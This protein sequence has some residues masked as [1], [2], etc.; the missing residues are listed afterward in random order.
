MPRTLLILL[1]LFIL[2]SEIISQDNS[3]NDKLRE[4]V[5]ESGQAEVTVPYTGRNEV[6]YLSRKLSVYS[7]RDRLV[8]I[9]ISPLTL[10]W[11]ISQDL[12][13][14][15]IE[16][17]GAKGL[18]T[19]SGLAQAM[20][21]NT[22][23]TYT[24]Y[25]SIMKYFSIRYPSLC[26]LDTIGY[27]INNRL[28]LALKISD[29]AAT[30]ENEPEVFYS[31]TMHGDET[32]GFVLM[33]RFIDYLLKNYNTVD[34]VRNLVDNLEIWINPLA[35]PD[36][37][38]RSGNTITS[39]VRVNAEGADLNRRFPD[40]LDPTIVVAK[41]N[42]DM[43]KFMRKR[44][45]VISANF[46]GGA[47][48]VNYPWDRWFSKY[49]AD[50]SWFLDISRA[51]ADTV[52]V[53]SATGYMTDESDGVT[54]GADW[55]TI[56]G[57]RQDFVTWEL[58]GREV[59]IELDR[60]K[61][62]PAA[63]LELLWLYN[64][65]SLLGYLENALS[66]IHGTVR[67]SATYAPVGAKVFISGHDK[68]SSHVYSDTLNGAFVRMLAP[69]SYSVTFSAPGYKTKTLNN[70][71][72]FAGQR[73]DIAVDM[74][75]GF[76]NIGIPAG[77]KPTLYPNPATTRLFAIL[78]EGFNGNINV[79][80][81]SISGQVVSRYNTESGPGL[82]VTT[83]ISRLSGGTYVIKFTSADTGNSSCGRF[84]V[85]K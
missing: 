43:I 67:D 41:E 33:L 85:V 71:D 19:A 10:E 23:P 61:L 53:Y 50:D 47:E 5:R 39:P 72:V 76:A 8:Y 22:Y 9:S 60:I 28:V 27:S 20:E 49:H 24:Q 26:R 29:N 42:I 56:Y 74:E 30:D 31:S 40:P 37:T 70:V 17:T 68:D 25:D 64:R 65:S 82:P 55:Y 58:Q 69:G 4:A 48:V 11:F 1:L 12:E 21:W 32:G 80:I 63:Q 7:V 54:R 57:G 6:N 51:Y 84:N 81:S 13:Y 45:F 34:R 78:P 2:P 36:G 59:T 52:H 35:N 14:N 3:N 66:G 83:D 79:T 77:D 62:T 46:H 44:R 18:L 73:T 15:I 16:D 38:Y 75:A